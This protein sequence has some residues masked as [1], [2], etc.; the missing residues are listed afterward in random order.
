MGRHQIIGSKSRI[1]QG[2]PSSAQHPLMQA[3]LRF[4][5]LPTHL[6]LR[7]FRRVLIPEG[8][9]NLK[10]LHPAIT[11]D[12]SHEYDAHTCTCCKHAFRTHFACSAPGSLHPA[13]SLRACLPPA[14]RLPISLGSRTSKGRHVDFCTLVMRARNRVHLELI[15][16]SVGAGPGERSR[17]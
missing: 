1:S 11:F 4:K 13:V 6:R 12:Q 8:I 7:N 15:V 5:P 17:R 9:S 2:Y 10:Q 14:N 3:A 16:V